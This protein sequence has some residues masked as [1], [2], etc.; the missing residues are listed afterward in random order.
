[1]LGERLRV[2]TG[3]VPRKIVVDSVNKNSKV[4][5]VP[6]QNIQP[7][8]KAFLAFSDLVS[9]LRAKMWLFP[10]RNAL[11]RKLPYSVLLQCSKQNKPQNL[12]LV[13]K[14]HFGQ[15]QK[16]RIFGHA[17]PKSASKYPD[18]GPIIVFVPL[19][20]FPLLTVF[21]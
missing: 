16:T 7:L 8:Q 17:K 10:I 11:T 3:K 12:I 5:K 2:V 21:K 1:M 18:F 19:K 13:P 6:A 9:Q 15:G 20:T 4:Q 14:Q